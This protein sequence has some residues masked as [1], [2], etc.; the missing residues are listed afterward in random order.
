M[1]DQLFLFMTSIVIYEFIKY[2]KF[3]L[4]VSQSIK[5][6]KKILKLFTL[7]FTSDFR[8]E[9]LILNYAMA[10]FTLSI[11]A[12]CIILIIIF[13]IMSFDFVLNTFFITLTSAEGMIKVTIFI[14]IY[15]ILRKKVL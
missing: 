9:K 3:Q 11:K 15:H 1:I 13:F 5:I 4:I 14:L 12:L 7:K 2:F 8:K 6:C 10:L